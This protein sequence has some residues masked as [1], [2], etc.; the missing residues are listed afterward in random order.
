MLSNV[1]LINGLFECNHFVIDLEYVLKQLYIEVEQEQHLLFGIESVELPGDETVI[2][3]NDIEDFKRFYLYDLKL[4]GPKYR[5]CNIKNCNKYILVLDAFYRLMFKLET[6]VRMLVDKYDCESIDW[7]YDNTIKYSF[8]SLYDVTR[9]RSF[10]DYYRWDMLNIESTDIS[11][12]VQTN[13]ESTDDLITNETRTEQT[14]DDTY[15]DERA[16]EEYNEEQLIDF[17][18]IMF[19]GDN[20]EQPQNDL[21]IMTK[22]N[23]SEFKLMKYISYILY[24][25]IKATPF[26]E[27]DELNYLIHAFENDRFNKLLTFNIDEIGYD[28]TISK[29]I[30]KRFNILLARACTFKQCYINTTDIRQMFDLIANVLSTHSTITISSEYKIDRKRSAKTSTVQSKIY[31]INHYNEEINDNKIM[32]K[33]N[34]IH[35][36]AKAKLPRKT[37]IL[38]DNS[39]SKN[40]LSRG[41]FY[42]TINENG[43]GCRNSKWLQLYYPLLSCKNG[44]IDEI[45]RFKIRTIQSITNYFSINY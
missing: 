9:M 12:N 3:E 27:R 10:I 16:Y 34:G 32:N 20:D 4:L 19:G 44:Y 31:L 45:K 28:E 18:E 43:S 24:Q 11:T 26:S 36:L 21:Y 41:L 5:K 8:G 25:L 33:H 6:L 37:C 17:N 14:I 22:E 35:E 40:L 2:V 7:V 13:E 38:Q 23:D 30:I 29:D 39:S 1:S 42:A 15:Y